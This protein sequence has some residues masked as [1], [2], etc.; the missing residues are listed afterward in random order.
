MRVLIVGLFIVLATLSA[1][2]L[3]LRPVPRFP[4]SPSPLHIARTAELMK[5]LT[6]AGETGA[7]F[8]QQDGTFEAWIFPVKLLSAF[9][10]TVELA[11][12]P[13]PIE[14]NPLAA[15]IEVHPERTTITYSHAAFTVK[16]HMFVPRGDN[17]T[18]G[19][20]V[21]FEIAS[22]RPLHLTFRFQPDM[23]RMWPAPNFGR[24]SAEWVPQGD[25]GY[26]VLHTDNPAFSG[27]VA[28]PRAT[29]GILPPYQERP[30]TYPLELKLS[31]DPKKDSELFFP[32]LMA[33]GN[34]A[35]SLGRQLEAANSRLPQLYEQ[36]A[37][38]WAHF[39]DKRLVVETP[40]HAFDDA[41][42]WAAVAIDQARVK[43]HD[44]TGMIAG[45]NASG[46]SARPGFAWFFGRDT[47]WTLYAAHSY[48]DFALSRTALEFL[49]RRQRADGKMMH[50]FSQTADLADWKTTPYFYAA[51]DATPLFVMT[52]DD[53][54]NTS[55]DT[56]FLR[57]HWESVKRA[58][59]F[60]RAHDSDGDGIYENTEG[61]GWV[62][63]WPGGM[64]HQEIYLAALD[65]QSCASMAHLA[66][67][68]HDDALARAAHDQAEKI[69][70]KLASEYYEESKQFYAFSRNADGTTDKTATIYPSVAWWTGELSLPRAEAML[71]RWASAEFSTDWGTRDVSD[72]EAIYDPISYHQ[73][74]VWPLFTG[75]VSL[76]EYRAGRALS[77]YSHLMQNV[78]LTYAQDL[79][80]VTELLSGE[81]LQPL[82]RSS[83]HQTWS[84]AMAFTP[85]IRG[86][87][88]LDWDVLH[89]TLRL[90][91]HLPVT[92]ESA[93]LR[94][95]WIGAS[96]FDLDFKRTGEHLIV[97][98]RSAEP[99][100]LCLVPQD[101]PREECTT[102]PGTIHE[103]RI[104]LPPVE[105]G[106]A[107]GLPEAGARTEQLKVLDEQYAANRLAIAV[108]APGGST[109][110]L[111]LRINR[112]GIRLSGAE[113]DGHSLRIH[114]RAG[115]GY[116]R[117]VITLSW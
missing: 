114:F 16:Q 75:W 42:R 1:Q 48:G 103:L 81:F 83:S 79:G 100:R 20:I 115:A 73:G 61:T 21:L 33:T 44:E 41:M 91:P 3:P 108:E 7:V 49:I 76:A 84:S 8:G 95:V 92:W 24:P 66:A 94:H 39:F 82:G 96:Q 65:Q 40:D 111:L 15:A 30:K 23:L 116:Q 34:N 87:F 68:M 26:Y 50:E 106:T 32:L 70:V 109:Q 22:L 78:G 59:E 9:R 47:L 12:Y 6:V 102:A 69:R 93:K 98:A 62:E 18:P 113:T 52:M 2:S 88:G 5:P 80:A 55:G 104:A 77:A 112:P 63:S 117:E 85:A 60:T 10:I 57:D 28:I 25:S 99:E 46:D 29:P 54:V 37:N 90:A 35:E 72:K 67:L 58:Y 11:D 64:P 4:M 71:N 45:Y 31:F 56:R 17:V 53:Y 101:A 13:V 97:E 107:H 14:L 43:F 19:P 38:H 27:A 89:H 110:E 105:V 86:L 74:T 51:A 36:T